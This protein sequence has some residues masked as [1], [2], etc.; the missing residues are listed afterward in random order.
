MVLLFTIS[1]NGILERLDFTLTLLVLCQHTLSVFATFYF[2]TFPFLHSTIPCILPTSIHKSILPRKILSQMH[3]SLLI[4]FCIVKPDRWVCHLSPCPRDASKRDLSLTRSAKPPPIL[5]QCMVEIMHFLLSNYSRQPTFALHSQRKFFTRLVHLYFVERS[6][7]WWLVSWCMLAASWLHPETK[8]NNHSKPDE[9]SL[10]FRKGRPQ[11]R[12]VDT[13]SKVRTGNWKSTL[14]TPRETGAIAPACEAAQ[15]IP[16]AA[17]HVK[18]K[19]VF[20]PCNLSQI[21]QSVDDEQ[22]ESAPTRKSL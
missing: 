20:G 9:T 3:S 11:Q 2:S 12:L 14:I 10:R 5:V 21:N 4:T 13:A 15:E 18:G 16:P 17:D 6:L 7:E 8:S 1:V 19:T 22:G